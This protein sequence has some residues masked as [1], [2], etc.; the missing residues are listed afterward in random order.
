MDSK[1]LPVI[2]N[3]R[4]RFSYLVLL[5][6]WLRKMGYNNIFVIDNCSTYGPLLEYYKTK[7]FEL[8]RLKN[9]YGYLALWN[10]GIFKKFLGGHYVYSDPDVVP[11][12]DCPSDLLSHMVDI[13]EDNPILEK[14]GIGLR[15]DDLPND[16]EYFK[17]IK[18]HEI[19]FWK[20]K[21]TA[22]TFLAP[23]DTTFALYRENQ[24][25]GHLLNS[26]RTNFPYIARHM[27][28]YT[29]PGSESLEDRYYQE[30]SSGV[31]HWT[32]VSLSYK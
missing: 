21:F 27:P 3:N 13:L 25:G 20:R 14:V 10:S 4:N 11:D 23:V 7:P 24:A 16:H 32:D 9:N 1:N 17:L 30:H 22:D 31:T 26:V 8:I 12:P 19:D 15:L 18:N 29:K 6:D 28:W 5:V 2:I